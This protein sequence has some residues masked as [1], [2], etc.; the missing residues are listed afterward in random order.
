MI[1]CKYNLGHRRIRKLIWVSNIN[2]LP[3]GSTF[4]FS[5]C[6]YID[7]VRCCV[8]DRTVCHESVP[9]EQKYNTSSPSFA[10][11]TGIPSGQLLMRLAF[12]WRLIA[13]IIISFARL[14]WLLSH[15]L[16]ARRLWWSVWRLWHIWQAV[17]EAHSEE[18][19]AI[20]LA[21]KPQTRTLSPP[22]AP[23]TFSESQR[24]ASAWLWLLL[25]VWRPS[26]ATAEAVAR[27][28]AGWQTDEINVQLLI[29]ELL[30]CTI[31][32]SYD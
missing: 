5:A 17:T 2:M 6:V 1:Q 22:T 4:W 13:A 25:P 32:C 9:R 15:G 26:E 20:I 21:S 12:I 24:E 28:P 19:P 3:N 11:R 16:S 29:N 30:Y 23:L 27:W 7:I 18:L 8:T 14:V 31:L 10:F